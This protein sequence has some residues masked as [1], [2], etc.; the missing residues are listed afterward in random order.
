M[1]EPRTSLKKTA[2]LAG[3]FYLILG[4]TSYYAIMYM[5]S[6]NVVK[7]DVAATTNN[8]LTHEVLF[9]S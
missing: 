5:P 8:M 4:I 7:G 1:I 6:H 3:L 2:R 9:R